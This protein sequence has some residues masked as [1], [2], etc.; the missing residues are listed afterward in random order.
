M[1]QV[2]QSLGRTQCG[3]S[4]LQLLSTLCPIPPLSSLSLSNAWAKRLS[5]KNTSNGACPLMLYV[6]QFG[7]QNSPPV[8]MI[9]RDF[10]ATAPG[11][12]STRVAVTSR[13][14]A[15]GDLLSTRRDQSA[16]FGVSA[17]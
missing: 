4:Y 9:L 5:S 1:A 15:L 8:A 10:R 12:P 17:R 11:R 2:F 16:V 7:I 14:V 3:T 13:K 6:N